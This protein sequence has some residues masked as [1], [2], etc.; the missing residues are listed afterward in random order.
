MAQKKKGTTDD[1]SY[2][3]RKF[4]QFFIYGFS[5]LILFF[6]LASWGFFGAMPSFEELENPESNLA[7][8]VISSDGVTIGKFYN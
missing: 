2:Y 5:A 1:I 3:K 7:T 4:W 6:L 8:E